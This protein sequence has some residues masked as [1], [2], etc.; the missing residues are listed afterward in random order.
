MT[1]LLDNEPSHAMSDED[2]WR[3]RITQ[4]FGRCEGTEERSPEVIDS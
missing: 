4:A 3:V 2:D 1:H